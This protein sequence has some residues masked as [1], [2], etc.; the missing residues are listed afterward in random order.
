VLSKS[1]VKVGFVGF[2]NVFNA[3]LGFA[4]LAAVAKILDLD[5]FGKYALLTT[6]LVS[7]S[8]LIDF[9]TNSVFVAKSISNGDSN[10][11]SVFLSA[12]ILLTLITFPIYVVAL[13]LLHEIDPVVLLIL[14]LGSI[15]YGINYTLFGFFQK[16]E[17]YGSLVLLNLLP[18]LIKGFFAL[19]IF[20]FAYRPSLT[21]S[22]AIFSLSIIASA[23]LIPL[24]KNYFKFKFTLV[25][26]IDLMKNA[27]PA[28]V[29]QII[30]ESWP[31]ISNAAAKISGGFTDVGIF[32]LASK[33]SHMFALASLSIFTVLLP[34]NANRKK[35]NLEYDF[36]ETIV[37]SLIILAFS[38][39]AIPL[40]HFLVTKLF[41]S[42][43]QASLTI[44]NVLI[45]SAAITS[46][47]SFIE[48]FF[49]VEQKT[50]YIM[51]INIGKLSVFIILC[52]FLIP[53]YSLSGLAFS[54]LT[55]SFCAIV[56]TILLI[57]KSRS[58]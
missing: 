44:I 20:F 32:S 9:G 48:N 38:G 43:F 57:K 13:A 26:I 2:G 30:V 36:T 14:F 27:Y 29:S 54:D 25:G 39:L 50:N 37:I 11:Y 47:H 8:K 17:K 6:L 7:I 16:D 3:L 56:F 42:K 34:K 31:T 52:S 24:S 53:I 21:Y 22:V 19:L 49:F 55:S 46:I 12:K 35:Q 5:S 41:G 15:A 58:F 28:G 1:L 4:F 18:S 45:F 10:L 23:L 40:T 51:Y 33:I